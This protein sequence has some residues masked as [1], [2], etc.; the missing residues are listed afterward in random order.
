MVLE[1]CSC[2]TLEGPYLVLCSSLYGAFG[3]RGAFFN[4]FLLLGQRITRHFL[5]LAVMS[6]VRDRE[7]MAKIKSMHI[8]IDTLE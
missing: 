4:P 7:L 8:Q 1:D 5:F 6:V 3:F 2:V